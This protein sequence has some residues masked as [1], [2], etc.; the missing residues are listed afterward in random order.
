MVSRVLGVHHLGFVRVPFYRYVFPTLVLSFSVSML[1]SYHVQFILLDHSGNGLKVFGAFWW[2]YHPLLDQPL[3][4]SPYLLLDLIP[5]IALQCVVLVSESQNCLSRKVLPDLSMAPISS[6]TLFF[7]A[8]LHSVFLPTV[9]GWFH[10]Y[11]VTAV[12]HVH[13]SP[14]SSRLPQQFL[15]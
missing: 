2:C 12:G 4:I 13:I 11:L 5:E 14:L 10:G 6:Y 9:L 1:I 7:L 3:V 15:V 8:C